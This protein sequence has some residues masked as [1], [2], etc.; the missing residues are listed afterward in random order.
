MCII[1]LPSEGFIKH[2][3]DTTTNKIYNIMH[4]KDPMV[5]TNPGYYIMLGNGLDY[6]HPLLS[7]RFSKAIEAARALFYALP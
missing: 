4:C 6:S 1:R 3:Q 2:Y 5:Y 7:K